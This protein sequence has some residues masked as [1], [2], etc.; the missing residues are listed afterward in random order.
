MSLAGSGLPNAQGLNQLVT[1]RVEAAHCVP[2]FDGSAEPPLAY[3]SCRSIARTAFVAVLA[4]F[5]TLT[6]VPTVNGLPV[7]ATNTRSAA[8]P[9]TTSFRKPPRFR[10]SRP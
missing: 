9:P 8:H 1:F 7:C 5:A 6:F 4:P 10:N 2:A 3:G